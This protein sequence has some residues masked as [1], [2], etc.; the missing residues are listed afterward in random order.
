VQPKPGFTLR[1]VGAP[2]TPKPGSKARKTLVQLAAERQRQQKAA[3]EA[4]V[5]VS[6][7]DR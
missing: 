3:R 1:K 7:E 4:Q 5:R 6:C 2:G